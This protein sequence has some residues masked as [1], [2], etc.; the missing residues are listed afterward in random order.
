MREAQAKRRQAVR[1][2]PDPLEAEER[3]FSKKLPSLLRRYKGRFVAMYR[4]RVIGS[5]LDDEEL[6][7]RMYKRFGEVPFYIAKVEQ[8]PTVYEVPSPEVAN[9]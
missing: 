2:D 1:L 8:T 9:H 6:G 5:D 4:G 7:R 3:A